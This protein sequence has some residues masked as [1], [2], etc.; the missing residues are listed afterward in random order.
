M[1]NEPT[2]PPKPRGRKPLGDD[3]KD[4][5]IG[6]RVSQPLYEK[7]VKHVGGSREVAEWIRGLIGAAIKE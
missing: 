5:T 4:H 6:V 7:I 3:A 2:E 1:T